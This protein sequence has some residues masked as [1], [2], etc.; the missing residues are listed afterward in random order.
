[1]PRRGRRGMPA[2]CGR[3][4]LGRSPW[5]VR[6]EWTHMQDAHAH[7]GWVACETP[8]ADSV[9]VYDE[10]RQGTARRIEAQA[11][12]AAYVRSMRPVVEALQA[13]LRSGGFG[14][15]QDEA[16]AKYW[17]RMRA[18]QEE[19]QLQSQK[20]LYGVSEPGARARYEEKFGCARWTEAALHACAQHSPIV[21][22]G[23]GAGHWQRE[24]TR[25]GAD[26]V[27]FDNGEE[28]PL[29]AQG[30][31]TGRVLFGDHSK[32]REHRRRTLFLCYP[33]ANDMPLQ[34]LALYKG[35]VLLYV[36]EGRGGVN[37][38][39]EFFDTLEREWACEKVVLLEPF[40]EC[41]ERLFVL[42]RRQP[43][44]RGYLDAFLHLFAK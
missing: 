34:C 9:F 41:F 37:G 22:I 24:L 25:V 44:A 27:A 30:T 5:V 28:M 16:V 31:A 2:I 10:L 39:Q 40:A 4:C 7:T 26:V 21:E 12:L 32:I 36:G 29:S 14:R 6:I 15:N 1:M 23:A 35:D 8:A 33:P 43:I 17:E 38:T 19:V 20:L 11:K 13:Q 42:R 3:G 18:L